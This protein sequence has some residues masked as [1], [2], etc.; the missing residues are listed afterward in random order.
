MRH[1][2]VLIAASDDLTSELLSEVAAFDLPL[3]DLTTLRPATALDELEA[4]V[5]T[6]GQAILRR[7]L[8]VAWETIDA[9][10]AAAYRHEHS[11][12]AVTADGHE[13]LTVASRFGRLHL[14]CQVVCHGDSRTHVLPG[15]AVLPAHEGIVKGSSG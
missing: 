10:V 7:L 6:T 13:P 15:H 9:A 8:E 4:T 5:F 11:A 1:L 2:R 14:R 12:E 3:P